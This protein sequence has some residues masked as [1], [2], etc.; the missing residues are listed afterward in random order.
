MKRDRSLKFSVDRLTDRH[1]WVF[2][3]PFIVGLLLVGLP[4]VVASVRYSFSALS[5]DENGFQVA[6]AGWQ[7][8][9]DALFVDVS[10]VKTFLMSIA[11]TVLQIPVIVFFSLF[12]AT[13]LNQK[14]PG[15][16]VFR[17]VFFMPMILMSGVIAADGMSGNALLTKMSTAGGVEMTGAADVSV[18]DWA[19]T[20]FMDKLS[21]NES[22][23]TYLMSVVDNIFSVVTM[24]CVQILIFLSAL[25]N[26]SPSVYEAAEVEGA[27]GWDC[28]WKITLPMI[29]PMLLVVVCY[30]VI[31]S[32]TSSS[33]EVMSNVLALSND[34]T[35]TGLASAMAWMYFLVIMVLLLAICLWLKR[36][37]ERNQ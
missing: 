20:Y 12:V 9:H 35:K 25:Q 30:T 23:S 27:S 11:Q 14:L 17:A 36:V 32:F 31:D 8:Y 3:S 16:T 7:N 13:L 10:F 18:A 22:V 6:A 33:N 4:V 19:V 28:Y 26:I 24:S 15:R 34:L 2:L 1:S 5:I 21:F 37:A 29:S